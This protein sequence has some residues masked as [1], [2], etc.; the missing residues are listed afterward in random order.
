M[1]DIV[2]QCRKCYHFLYIGIKG[3]KIKNLADILG[4]ADCPT[5]G[6][7]ADRNW[8]FVG[9]GDYEEDYGDEVDE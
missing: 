3:R 9:L 1:K 7:E 6:E 4:K 2:F 5:C 8:V